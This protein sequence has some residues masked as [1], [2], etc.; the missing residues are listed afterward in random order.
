MTR[1][2]KKGLGGPCGEAFSFCLPA[3][4]ADDAAPLGLGEPPWMHEVSQ[5]NKNGQQS[6][7]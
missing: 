4:E 6:I 7:R 1:V 5:A 3:E 2:P